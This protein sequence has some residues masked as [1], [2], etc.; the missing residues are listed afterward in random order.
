MRLGTEEV[1]IDFVLGELSEPLV[2]PLKGSMPLNSAKGQA[3]VDELLDLLPDTIS[4]ARR[5]HLLQEAARIY[6]SELEKPQEALIVLQ[7]AFLEDVEYAPVIA[8]LA[9]LCEQTNAW[10]SLLP[11][12][13]LAAEDRADESP[14]VAAQI[15]VQVAAWYLDPLEQRASAEHALD[16]ALHL[17]P[18]SAPALE[19]SCAMHWQSEDWLGFLH[20]ARRLLD[21]GVGARRKL[22]LLLQC[23]ALAADK[24]KDN[25][26]AIE[27]YR[28][29]HDFDQANR[30]AIDALEALYRE[31]GATASL[32]RVLWTKA[33]LL[34]S[35]DEQ[36]AL[37]LEVAH[38]LEHELD[39]VDQARRIY[40]RLTDVDA[41]I[42]VLKKQAEHSQGLAKADVF[43]RMARMLSHRGA[44]DSTVEW[45]LQEAISHAPDH[46]GAS[47][48][49][50]ERYEADNAWGKAVALYE[51]KARRSGSK[52]DR[53]KA[54][55]QAARIYKERL[56]NP[57]KAS[58]LCLDARELIPGLRPAAKLLA[59]IAYENADT[60]ALK[61]LVAELMADDGES[62]SQPSR[63]LLM[64]GACARADGELD[65]ASR[66]FR[67]VLASDPHD[68]DCL[69]A[70]GEMA[71]EAGHDESVVRYFETL[72]SS[73]IINNA[74]ER[75]RL[76]Y[77][78]GEAQRRMGRGD[79]ALAHYAHTRRH[80]PKH[81][82]VQASELALRESR[83]EW[84]A[85]VATKRQRLQTANDEQRATLY[86]ELGDIESA[87]LKSS[88]KALEDYQHSLELRGNDRRVLQRVLDLSADMGQ[89][90]LALQTIMHIAEL[91]KDSARKGS[92]FHA[93]AEISRDKV[94]DLTR[95]VALYEDCLD[96]YF[97]DPSRVSTEQ[98]TRYM[99]PFADLDAILTK[100][101]EWKKQELSYRR[102]IKRLGP[103]HK[104][105][106]N[107]WHSLAEIYRTRLKDYD[108][109]VAALE[110]A[111]TLAPDSI[112][113]REQLAELYI[114]AGPDQLDKA[115]A[116]HQSIIDLDMHRHSSYSALAELYGAV[117]RHD[118]RWNLCQALS[119]LQKSTPGQERFFSEN[120]LQAMKLPRSTVPSGMWPKLLHPAQDAKISSLL[121]LLG[122]P[123]LACADRA[124]RARGLK[125]KEAV[126]PP[127]QS[128]QRLYVLQYYAQVLG[129]DLPTMYV[130]DRRPGRVSSDV[131]VVK[132]Q[133]QPILVVGA[134]YLAVQD[135]SER[136]F[137]AGQQLCRLRQENWLSMVFPDPVQTQAMLDWIL[138]GSECRDDPY[139]AKLLEQVKVQSPVAIEQLRMVSER[140][141]E[142]HHRPDAREW[143][144]G[145]VK[146]CD[147]VGLIL[148]S[149]LTAG[150]R[151]I[152]RDNCGATMERVA[153]LVRFSVSEPY[154]EIRDTMR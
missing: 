117:G 45:N 87:E 25:T 68:A 121:L 147:R 144:H 55:M 8:S 93:A 65:K 54:T 49:L 88:L 113:G 80:D 138:N 81:P 125:S 61:P 86:A 2:Q 50:M 135:E 24:L 142:E 41:A 91:E 94:G 118:A 7:A 151:G 126:A 83:G 146:S 96:A 62:A 75:A 10:A 72:L 89:W 139:L 4:P 20:C 123:L 52:S 120:R 5:I 103:E 40:H 67:Q 95:A 78:L 132:S 85:V 82:E 127:E 112:V 58:A 14:I 59:D 106:G 149:D 115:I 101:R 30:P 128:D 143:H 104:L 154:F 137:Q 90:P 51:E 108:A 152:V 105:L 42:A 131:L 16:N 99:K 130:Q 31:T 17:D 60:E 116:E 70:L 69:R 39:N 9:E 43:F 53:I 109:A 133:I 150:A 36:L 74:K 100:N 111:R 37:K 71:L 34:T 28:A 114:K 29:A 48:L 23:G 38:L 76:H 63:L 6:V 66:L 73:T 129:L 119:V 107:L 18:N 148:S 136:A 12:L 64:A 13:M 92:Y 11:E 3:R 1:E 110:V 33:K 97:H 98:L 44:D 56:N 122:V 124:P 27:H 26:L 140:I 21:R 134:D 79:A 22:E 15:W 32:C 47:R 19:L 141:Q 84:S 77:Q 46:E 57:G 35:T 153:E 145:Q 102:M